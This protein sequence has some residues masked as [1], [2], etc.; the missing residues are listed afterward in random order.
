MKK[1][2][3]LCLSVLA[4]QA[5]TAQ[6]LEIRDNVGTVLNAD[7]VD[8]TGL[9][10]DFDIQ[11]HGYKVYNVS[12]GSV[13]VSCTRTEVITVTG[14]ASALC[15]TVCSMDYGA[16]AMPVLMAPGGAQSIASGGFCDLF[17]LHYKPINNTGMTLYRVS[18]KNTANSNDSAHFFVRFNATV[19]VPEISKT[20]NISAYPN[21]ANNFI[22]VD[23]DQFNENTRLRIVDVLGSTVKTIEINSANTRISTAD[24]KEGIYFYSLMDRNKAVIT[25]RLVISR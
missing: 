16:G 14:T 12:G 19:S 11:A 7:T 3:T 22:N 18:F 17:V 2:F 10:S 25:R 8:H 21:P 15:W 20:A 6:S 24:L 4:I 1:I 5:A 13:S 9:A 23:I